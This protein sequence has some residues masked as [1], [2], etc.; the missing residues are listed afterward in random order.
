MFHSD[1]IN[2]PLFLANDAPHFF[3]FNEHLRCLLT[4][5]KNA[6]ADALSCKEKLI[7]VHN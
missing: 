3:F 6:K 1:K 4:R 5:E 7:V 2:L